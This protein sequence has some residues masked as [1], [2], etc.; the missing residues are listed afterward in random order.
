[1]VYLPGVHRKGSAARAKAQMT[2]HNK[3]FEPHVIA[4]S[5][6]DTVDFPNLDKIHHNVF[7]LS[8]AN[9]F[10]LGLYKNGASRSQVF[11]KACVC[12]VYCNIHAQ[13]SGIVVVADGD[14]Y[15][16]TGPDGSYKIDG[17]P[18]GKHTVIA[19]HEKGGEQ[20]AEVEIAEGKALTKDF[21]LDASGF[22]E[23]P[24]TNKYGKPYGKDDD[25]RY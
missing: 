7:S 1:M 25:A 3:T 15:A 19:W 6:G 24:H 23:A 4:V 12:R 2:S 13:M 5:A 11:A 8:E 10:D 22:K 18:P 16:V 20:Q 9:K 21:T 17:L 14:A